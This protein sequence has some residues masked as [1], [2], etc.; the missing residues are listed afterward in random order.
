MQVFLGGVRFADS[1]KR[2]PPKSSRTKSSTHNE[3][4]TRR[5][6]WQFNKHS[7]KLL[8]MDILMT[9]TC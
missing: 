3:L 7:R 6:T 2:T 4:K 8:M 1:A 9:E 5:P